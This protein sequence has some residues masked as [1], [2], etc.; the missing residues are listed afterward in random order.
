MGK[1]K[2]NNK[3]KNDN[4]NNSLIN[5]IEIG[6]EKGFLTYDEIN[7]SFPQESFS[8][9]EMDNFLETLGELGIEVVD[10]A[11]KSPG[12]EEV[13]GAKTETVEAERVEDP[14]RIYMREMG[15]VSLLKRE[16]EIVLAMQIEG[17]MEE[18]QRLTLSSPFAIREVFRVAARIKA[19]KASLRDLLDEM[20]EVSYNEDHTERILNKIDSSLTSST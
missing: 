12:P 4:N 13:F 17:A 5:L 8:V 15:A 19:E 3:K 2:S 18:L 1:R 10:T 11:E 6:K 14:V 9:D 7:D 20:E 16:D